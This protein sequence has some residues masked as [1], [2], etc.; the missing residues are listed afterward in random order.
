MQKFAIFVLPQ[1]LQKSKG[2]EVGQ[3][4]FIFS[5]S[6]DQDLSNAPILKIFRLKF[7]KINNFESEPGILATSDGVWN[8]EII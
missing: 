4:I 8:L 1:I 2:N 3:K 5:Q 7:V 6:I